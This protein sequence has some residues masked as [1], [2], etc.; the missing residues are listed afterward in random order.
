MLNYETDLEAIFDRLFMPQFRS[1]IRDLAETKY[2]R[3]PSGDSK[4]NSWTLL[5]FGM[6]DS[7]IFFSLSKFQVSFVKNFLQ[8][9]SCNWTTLTT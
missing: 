9:S 2:G 5:D 7:F 1:R 6:Y 4:A 3:V 8:I